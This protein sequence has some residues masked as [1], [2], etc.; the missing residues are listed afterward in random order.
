MMKLLHNMMLIYVWF[1]T[2]IAVLLVR[3]AFV[4]SNLPIMNVCGQCVMVVSLLCVGIPAEKDP[5]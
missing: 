3:C 5:G 2:I 4:V 1:S